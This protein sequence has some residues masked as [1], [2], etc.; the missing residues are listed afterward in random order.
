MCVSEIAAGEIE[1][2]Q[3]LSGEIPSDEA[4]PA[5]IFTRI[6]PTGHGIG[7]HPNPLALHDSVKLGKIERQIGQGILGQVLP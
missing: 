4:E 3:I 6:E 1:P 7:P 2:A 5:K